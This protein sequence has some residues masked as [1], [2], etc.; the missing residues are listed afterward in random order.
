MINMNMKMLAAIFIALTIIFAGLF[1]GF[2]AVDN[3]T[4]A[5]KDTQL[6]KSQN[7]YSDAK[8]SSALEAAY[9]HWNNITIENLANVSA[10]YTDNAT[11]HWIGGPL[12]GVYSGIANIN[13]TWSKFF[14][15]W[16][17]V[18]FYAETPPTVVVNGN[19]SNV[20]STNQ[21]ILTPFNNETQVQYL[22]VSYT[23][24][25]MYMDN[26]WHIYNEIWHITGSGY[27]SYA[28]E[29]AEYNE[30]NALSLQHW[31]QIAIENLSLIMKEYANNATLHWIG[32]PLNGTYSG[33][34]SINSTWN[35]FFTAWKAVWFYASTSTTNNP[36]ISINGNMATVSAN[37]TQFIVQNATT[38]AFQYIN[39]T[40]AIT[41]YNYGF[42][43]HLGENSFKIVNETFHIT[44]SGNLTDL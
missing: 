3:S 18:W 30:I 41:Y 29:F 7:A 21:F 33:I 20:T 1:I 39:T 43:G 15:T 37:F 22:N 44:G 6:K 2:Y 31:N 26:S 12:N 34:T 14:K 42:N 32:G 28:Q 23:L 19:Y 24:D 8:A 36:E 40:Y 35:K 5:H 9:A 10:G 25:M 27:V 38:N 11:L 4:I 16:S 13:S 17:A